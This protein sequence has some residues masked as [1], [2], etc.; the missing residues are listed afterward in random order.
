MVS[1]GFLEPSTGRAERGGDAQF[2][3]RGE[4]NCC[5]WG[6]LLHPSATR[7]PRVHSSRK[8]VESMPAH[9]SSLPRPA[10][11]RRRGGRDT[12]TAIL[13]SSPSASSSPQRETTERE[14]HCG[15]GGC[16]SRASLSEVVESEVE[17]DGGLLWSESNGPQRPGDINSWGGSN[18]PGG[19]C[20]TAAAAAVRG[21]G[22]YRAVAGGAVVAPPLLSWMG[23]GQDRRARSWRAR[24]DG[25]RRA[26]APRARPPSPPPFP[27]ACLCLPVPAPQRRTGGEEYL[28][29][30]VPIPARLPPLILILPSPS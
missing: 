12:Q 27:C 6:G 13:A 16:S 1:M 14:E 22:R 21:T 24:A 8:P 25:A 26:G 11:R 23:D 29:P 10:V 5:V 20:G 3:S 18:Q 17:R 15:D 7:P 2:N 28:T 19:W 4:E 9:L 30:H